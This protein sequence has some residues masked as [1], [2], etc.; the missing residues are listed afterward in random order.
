MTTE[1][2]IPDYLKAMIA[3][4]EVA[5]M[6]LESGRMAVPRISLKGMKFRFK[7]NGEEVERLGGDLDCIIVGI[8]PEHG[9]AKTF[10]AGKYNPDSA[11]PPD[12]SSADGVAP[13]GWINDP[14]NS[15]CASCPNNKFGSAIGTSGK[16]SK[17]CRD[18]RLLYVVRAEELNQELPKVWVLTVTVSSLKNFTNYGR[19]LAKKGIPSPSLVITRVSFDEDV[20]FPKLVFNPLGVLTEDLA[21]R[22][23]NM[24]EEKEWHAALPPPPPK[25]EKM[26]TQKPEATERTA[27]D[28]AE[29]VL[30]GWN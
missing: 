24:A 7:E 2:V 4:S 6:D 1:L 27:S 10:Y 8:S 22:S 19:L 17:A 5:S 21:K 26:E 29:T 28:S 25:T 9:T 23:M 30:D 16:K 15:R 3:G 18:S 12:C 11:D 13:D 14:V 20:D